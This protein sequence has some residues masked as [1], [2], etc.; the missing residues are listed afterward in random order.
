MTDK[1]IEGVP[2]KPAFKSAYDENT[3][4]DVLNRCMGKDI[5]ELSG[6]NLATKAMASNLA[7][8]TN[9]LEK[10][11]ASGDADSKEGTCYV[12]LL[13]TSPSPRDS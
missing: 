4:D 2:E 10:E 11:M 7:T 1:G 13:Y 9:K 6:F 8:F 12:C 3:V 5:H